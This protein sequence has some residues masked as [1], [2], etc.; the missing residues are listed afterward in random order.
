MENHDVDYEEARLY[1]ACVEEVAPWI[2]ANIGHP[3]FGW[4]EATLY[5]GFR[6]ILD[7]AQ[8]SPP[9]VGPR[10]AN[11][12]L[13]GMR[14]SE[15]PYKE[16]IAAAC[17]LD[18]ASHAYEDALYGYRYRSRRALGFPYGKTITSILATSLISMAY[19]NYLYRNPLGLSDEQCLE[20]F[21]VA[22]RGQARM[23]YCVGL[24]LVWRNDKKSGAWSERATQYALYGP[25]GHAHTVAVALA[26]GTLGLSLQARKAL[27]RATQHISVTSAILDDLEGLAG[28]GDRQIGEEFRVRKT[29]PLT[30][31]C[32]N[33][34]RVGL[35]A[36]PTW[37]TIRATGALIAP[38]ATLR[39]Q[40]REQLA[41]AR[42]A[43]H[44]SGLLGVAAEFE[45]LF[46]D[47][48]SGVER[49]FGALSRS[50]PKISRSLL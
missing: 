50:E 26:A 44:D 27:A 13:K 25:I 3:E 45:V 2:V 49:A 8:W 36:L 46:H 37:Q 43:M 35:G 20:L 32:A 41:H 34:L 10:L 29:A 17:R 18:L 14:K 47:M 28:L 9:G 40:A 38:I 33:L 39:L 1:P 7:Y 19:N 11:C 24:Q 15:E 42:T 30:A 31:E 23:H 12:I 48:E 5:E 4:D 6:A 16:V 22:A 21:D